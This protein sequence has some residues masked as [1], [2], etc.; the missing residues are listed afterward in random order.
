M[1]I[2][3]IASGSAR[4]FRR[5]GLAIL[6]AD[7]LPLRPQADAGAPAL[8]NALDS[9]QSPVE[10]RITESPVKPERKRRN[11]LKPPV[12]SIEVI[13]LEQRRWLTIK[14]ASARF[15][16]F[17][18]KSLRHLVAQAE[19]YAKYP[20]AGLRSNGLIGCICRPAGQRKILIDAAKFDAWLSAGAIGD[21]G[22]SPTKVRQPGRV[23]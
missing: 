17:S 8:M 22:S 4:Y 7:P 3:T 5:L 11:S 21:S 1:D 2:K 12:T 20:K 18:E 14:E 15:P 6:G 9:L 10:S 16:C 23:A 19:A 13:P